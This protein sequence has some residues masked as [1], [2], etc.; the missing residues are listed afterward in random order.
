MIQIPRLF[1][2]LN[3]V[4]GGRWI[5]TKLIC[6]N[7][8]YFFSIPALITELQVG[9][10]V[11]QMKQRWSVKNHIGTTHAIAVCNLCEMAVGLTAE[12][13]IPKNL[14]WIPKGMKVEYLHKASGTLTA[15]CEIPADRFSNDQLIVQVVV[16]NEDGVVVVKA[17]IE[18]YI[19]RK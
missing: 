10:V 17:G 6:F 8:P 7:A 4:P 14:R 1:K 5:F 2:K 18:L 19:S 9:K 12:V 15:T 3:S 16:H 13:T 11:V